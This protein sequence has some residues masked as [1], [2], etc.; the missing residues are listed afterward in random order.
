M[1]DN[2]HTAK[3]RK[4]NS[5][6]A[7]VTRACDRCKRRKVKCDGVQPCEFCSRAEAE[8]TFKTTYTRGRAPSI[9]Q[10]QSSGTAEA[11]G[12]TPVIAASADES[13]AAPAGLNGTISGQY[14]RQSNEQSSGLA[15]TSTSPS[16]VEST[17]KSPAESQT[18]LHGKYIGPASGVSF[19]QRV[20]TRLG[21]AV[22]FSHPDSIFTF[23]DAPLSKPE[24]DL[25]FCFMLPRVD[26]QR[27]IDRYFDFAMPTYRFLH[28]PT[29]QTWFTEFYE[30]YGTMHAVS[31]ASARIALLLMVLAHGRVY[32]P[33]DDKPGPPD[34]R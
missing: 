18:G 13:T 32:M 29:I 33:D 5:E 3:K 21:Q 2:S 12:G 10:A 30:T 4:R 14:A 9:Q 16:S 20:Q 6:R 8:C 34:L 7:R 28:R 17:H 31:T 19:L 27:L 23:G 26:A 25:S 24:E 1:D 22:S 15:V 11:P